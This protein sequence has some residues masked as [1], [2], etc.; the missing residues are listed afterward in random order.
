MPNFLIFTNKNLKRIL[1]S[2]NSC[3]IEIPAFLTLIILITYAREIITVLILKKKN[4]NITSQMLIL[5][6][7]QKEGKK[8]ENLAIFF[9]K[10]SKLSKRII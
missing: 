2:S 5:E 1:I 6:M 10:W 8:N 7:A 4:T 9:R 3:K